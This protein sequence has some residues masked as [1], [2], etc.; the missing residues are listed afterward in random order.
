MSLLNRKRVILAKP[1]GTYMTDAVPTGA[2][3]AILIS[4]LQVTPQ[5]ANLVSRDLIRPFFGN[6]TQVP[7][8]I[9]AK[10]T[11][12]VELAGAGTAG[13]APAWGA[14]M[15]GCA[16]S[17]TLLAAD[18]SGSAQAGAASTI[19]LAAAG[20][21]AVDDAYKGMY[22]I[23]TSGTGSGQTGI[24]AAYN[25]TTKVATMMVNWTTP[26]AAA[27]GYTV[28]ANAIYRPITDALEGLSIY[29]NVDGVL[30]KF[31]GSRGNVSIKVPL[32]GIPKLSFTFTGTYTTPTDTAMPTAVFTSWQQPLTVNNTNTSGLVLAGYAGAIMSDFNL[33]M[34]NQVTYRSLVGGTQSVLITDRKAQGDITVEATT[35]AAKDWWTASQN[36]VLSGFTLAHGTTAGNIVQLSAPQLQIVK[37]TYEDKDGVAM[38]KAS[39]YAV[40][41]TQND[42]VWISAR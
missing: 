12:D 13:T 1:E 38:L 29:F 19:T 39:L 35:V 14:L 2:A 27:T 10:V 3:N 26:P 11:F 30:H 36:A 31:I 22:I 33:D 17:E 4:N 16:F 20:S 42:E 41:L 40:P 32:W 21:S 7:A 37:P 24:I 23:L 15:R 28:K 34:G 6:F 25:G 9:S 5:E 18:L 8:A